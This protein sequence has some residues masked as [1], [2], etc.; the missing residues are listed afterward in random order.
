MRG[1]LF[2]EAERQRKVLANL[3]FLKW[4]RPAALDRRFLLRR[5]QSVKKKSWLDMPQVL[6]ATTRGSPKLATIEAVRFFEEE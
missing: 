5:M 3:I 4:L 6:M 1:S 2:L